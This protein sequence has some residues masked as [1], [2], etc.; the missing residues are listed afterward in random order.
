VGGFDDVIGL[1]SAFA[2]LVSKVFE[3][4]NQTTT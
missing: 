3:P 4:Y 1:C 2:T